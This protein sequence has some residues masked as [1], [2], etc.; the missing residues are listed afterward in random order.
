MRYAVTSLLLLSIATA[1]YADNNCA[2]AN[3]YLQQNCERLKAASESV[4]QARDEADKKELSKNQEAARQRIEAES[5]P[6][7]APPAPAIPQWQQALKQPSASTA[8]QHAGNNAAGN[9]AQAPTS[10][11]PIASLPDPGPTQF[12]SPKAVTLPGGVQVIPVP[13]D[14]KK[15]QSGVIKYY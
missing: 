12:S 4:Q 11:K 8:E 9:A 5:K 2:N 1:G 13:A 7:A 6:P 10:A 3:P 14:K 15:G